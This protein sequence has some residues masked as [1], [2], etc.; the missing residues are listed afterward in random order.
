MQAIVKVHSYDTADKLLRLKPD[1]I[2]ILLK[3][4]LLQ[5]ESISL[6]FILFHCSQCDL[7]PGLSMINQIVVFDMDLQ[8][9]R[10][11]KHDNNLYWK[12]RLRWDSVNPK[13]TLINIRKYFESL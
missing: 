2:N 10:E 7:C 9:L 8:R 1:D 6:C 3:T 12:D 11:E 4:I 5:A 13:Q